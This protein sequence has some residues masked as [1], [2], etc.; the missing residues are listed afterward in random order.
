MSNRRSNVVTTKNSHINS[1]QSKTNS[2]NQI[3]KNIQITKVVPPRKA[4]KEQQNKNNNQKIKVDYNSSN[5]F[6][7]NEKENN[8]NENERYSEYYEQNQKEQKYNRETSDSYITVEQEDGN[9]KS[10]PKYYLEYNNR[11]NSPFY[12][13]ENYEYYEENS[14]E[15]EEGDNDEMYY[16]ND[17][18][19]EQDEIEEQQ[20]PPKKNYNQYQ[21]MN[22]YYVSQKNKENNNNKNIIQKV[23]QNVI[24]RPIHHQINFTK[25]LK[26]K[27]RTTGRLNNY[28]NNS[29]TTNNTYNNNIYYINPIKVNDK[30][31]KEENLR[32][33]KQNN[34]KNAVYKNVDITINKRKSNR[35]KDYFKF[36]NIDKSQRNK[37]IDSAILI[38]SIFRSYL[39]KLKLSNVFNFYVSVKQGIILLEEVF[40][41]R[42]SYF[43]K[44]FKKYISNINEVFVNLNLL[45]NYLKNNNRNI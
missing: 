35:E 27:S 14:D 23:S 28:G 29:T 15:Y 12:R 33:K 17:E 30:N 19:Y 20:P 1:N 37:Y 22:K 36:H 41:K 24:S 9:I 25:D 8:N 7:S 26:R 13:K 38:Q 42:K 45:K 11:R 4:K 5:Y 21:N 3:S 39:L 44:K 6:Y 40:L 32:N 10:V 2:N 18:E 16:E 34:K 43:W 31:S